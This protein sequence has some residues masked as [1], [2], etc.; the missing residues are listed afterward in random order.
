MSEPQRIQL[1]RVKDWRLPAGAVAV[2]RPSKWSN[3]YRY[4]TIYGLARVP[5]VDGSPWEYEGRISAAGTT[6]DCYH[7]DGTWTHHT[8]R[9]MT[10]GECVELYERALTA[11]T[12]R[13]HLFQGIGRPWLTV[14]D[15]RRELSGRDLACWC[16][17][18]D[19]EGC[20]V[21]CHVDVLLRLARVDS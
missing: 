7:S 1:K 6:H 5:A 12:R 10:R 14:D 2:S 3:P 17:L 20:P 19:L 15:V 11:P 18:I 8:V 9:Y 16:P 21:P 4:R 13:L